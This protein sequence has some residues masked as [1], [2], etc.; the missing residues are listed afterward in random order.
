MYVPA[1]ISTMPGNVNPKN[2]GK[3]FTIP[4]DGKI[5]TEPLYASRVEIPGHSI[6][7][8]LFVVTEHDSVYAV[9][10]KTGERLWHVELLAAGETPADCRSRKF[11]LRV[12]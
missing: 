11:N 7:K 5:D 10:A 12:V 1:G 4:V 6:R 8:V 9:N 3:L 2:F